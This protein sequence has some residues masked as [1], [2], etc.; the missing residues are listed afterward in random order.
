VDDLLNEALG[1]YISPE[2][3]YAGF[4]L[5]RYMPALPNEIEFI[6]SNAERAILDIW[7]RAIL[8]GEGYSAEQAVQDARKAWEDGDGAQ[9]EQWYRDW[10]KENKDKW[11]FTEDLYDVRIRSEF[12]K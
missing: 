8:G 1:L 7:N 2:R 5:D 3:P 10:Y 9:V 6:D 11:V 12:G 4:T